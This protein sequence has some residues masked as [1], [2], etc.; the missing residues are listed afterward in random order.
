MYF[1]LTP[2]MRAQTPK[3]SPIV[4]FLPASN[5]WIRPWLP[6]DRDWAGKLVSGR[7]HVN[8]I[9][10]MVLQRRRAIYDIWWLSSQRHRVTCRIVTVERALSIV[11]GINNSDARIQ[12]NYQSASHSTHTPAGDYMI[13]P[14]DWKEVMNSPP[15]IFLLAALLLNVIHKFSAGNFEPV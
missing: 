5:S 6:V 8:V 15:F 11:A 12:L 3:Y 10:A 7:A 13:N 14:T 1:P 9:L 4:S 2:M